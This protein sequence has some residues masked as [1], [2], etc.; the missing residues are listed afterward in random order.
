MR[1]P[2]PTS[3]AMYTTT[4]MTSTGRMLVGLL[5]GRREAEAAGSHPDGHAHGGL[6]VAAVGTVLAGD[7]ECGAVIDGRADDGDAD[8]YVDGLLEVDEL[9]R[10][11]SLVVVHRDD[12]IELLADAAEEDG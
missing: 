2:T 10:D 3:T 4:T 7:V 12:E 8:R 1:T 5:Q 9:H 6:H 11:V